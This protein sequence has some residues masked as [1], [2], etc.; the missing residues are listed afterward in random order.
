MLPPVVARIAYGV[1]AIVLLITQTLLLAAPGRRVPIYAALGVIA[2]IP[3]LCD[4]RRLRIWAVPA[5]VLVMGLIYYD[6][7]AGVRFQQHAESIRQMQAT[8]SKAPIGP[9]VGRERGSPVVE[10]DLPAD[11][12][13]RSPR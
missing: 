6:Y 2:S 3:V 4:K 11:A 8:P 1:Y 5:I 7:Q 10:I 13:A 9:E 12:H